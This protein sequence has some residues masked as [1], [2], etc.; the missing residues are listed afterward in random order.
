MLRTSVPRRNGSTAPEQADGF[1][2]LS[3]LSHFLTELDYKDAAC[4]LIAT[5]TSLRDCNLPGVTPV[6]FRTTQNG[7]ISVETEFDGNPFVNA[8]LDSGASS[9]VISEPR[10]SGSTWTIRLSKD[11]RQA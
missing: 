1:I 6:P 4:G 3:V 9:S 11:K 10:S 5:T 7:L 8:I 2:G